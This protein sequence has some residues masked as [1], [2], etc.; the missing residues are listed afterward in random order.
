MIAESW[1]EARWK[2]ANKISR[3]KP[4]QGHHFLASLRHSIKQHN[5]DNFSFCFVRSYR[6]GNLWPFPSSYPACFAKTSCTIHVMAT[7]GMNTGWRS[8]TSRSVATH[9]IYSYADPSVHK[10]RLSC[11]ARYSRQEWLCQEFSEHRNIKP[12]IVSFTS[13]CCFDIGNLSRTWECNNHKSHLIHITTL[14][15]YT[16]R[17]FDTWLIKS[18]MTWKNCFPG[19]IIGHVIERRC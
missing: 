19:N 7:D 12:G 15:L 6:S 3:H 13:T 10:F 14:A 18:I 9:A 4:R 2:L 1:A 11:E 8:I 17:T 16:R 5:L